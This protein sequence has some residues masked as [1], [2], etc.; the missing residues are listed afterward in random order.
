MTPDTV[1]QLRA[2]RCQLSMRALARA[3]GVHYVTIWRYEQGRHPIP[4]RYVI[5]L[6][7]L[8]HHAGRP[9]HPCQHCGGSGVQP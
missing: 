5:R 9:V 8:A 3:L 6:A 7:V 1:R 2:E 4:P